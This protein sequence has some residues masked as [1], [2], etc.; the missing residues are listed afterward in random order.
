MNLSA[1]FIRRAIATTLIMLGIMAFGIFAYRTLPVS[2]LPNVDFPT[3]M[4]SAGLPGASPY[5]MA[6]AV[7]TPL[8]RQ[9]STIE[10]LSSMNSSRSLGSTQIVLQFDLSRN[11]DAAAQDVQ[12]AISRAGGQLPPEMPAPPSY[13]KVNPA[14]APILYVAVD[15]QTL[16]L[17]DVDEYAQ[18]LMAQRISMVSGVAQVQVFGSQKYAVRVQLDP[19]A[20]AS[21]GI[22]ID[23]VRLALNSANVNIP[24]GSLYGPTKAYTI[25]ATGQLSSA[26][27]FRP[28]IVSYSNGNP[29]RLEQLGNVLNSVQDDKVAGWFNN[30]RSVILAI[31]RQPGTNTVAVVDGVREL[32]PKFRSDIPA[33]V[34]LG[35]LYDRSVSI[36]NSISD[37][38]FT[39]FLAI[40]L[41][42]GVIFEG[43]VGL[44]IK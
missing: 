5:T 33:S 38:K 37:V 43:F 19:D 29:V 22:G 2:D 27:A 6:A 39:L 12:A 13:Q 7:A 10:G 1:L 41:V 35:I 40:V 28:L 21:R 20:L 34:N 44:Y 32:L 4:V 18:T 16:P 14:A 17:S 3:I 31:Q 30:V 15:S 9:F 23:S 24:G 8:E 25:Q 36:R 26:G 11:I 42:V